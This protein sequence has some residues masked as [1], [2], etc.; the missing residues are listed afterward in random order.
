MQYE[1]TEIHNDKSRDQI[2]KDINFAITSME[3]RGFQFIQI[4][5]CPVSL[6]LRLLFKKVS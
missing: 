2:E 1:V 5:S 4:F 3:K 6:Y